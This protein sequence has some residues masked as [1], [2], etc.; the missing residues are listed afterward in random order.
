MPSPPLG[1]NDKP[2]DE[3]AETNAAEKS[4]Q[5][6]THPPTPLMKEEQICFKGG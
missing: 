6:D 1:I 3:T 4:N 5:V 2:G